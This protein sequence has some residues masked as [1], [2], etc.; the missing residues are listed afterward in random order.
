MST[1]SYV[2]GTCNIGPAEMS[3]RR[4]GGWLAVAG[5][6][7]LSI[8]LYAVGASAVWQLTTWFPASL[9]AVGFIQARSHFCAYFGFRGVYNFDELGDEQRVIMQEAQRLDRQ[10]AL[11]IAVQS[12]AIGAVVALAAF[13]LATL[14]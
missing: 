10:R 9:A 6:L 13:A 4:R 11:K 1:E 8:A 12:A 5:T 7:F 14:L 2:A 3:R